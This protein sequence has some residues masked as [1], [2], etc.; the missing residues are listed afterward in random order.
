VSAPTPRQA[1]LFETG[2]VDWWREER[3]L[4]ARGIEWIAGLDEAGRGPLAGPVVAAAVVARHP[5]RIE[6]MNDS[7][8]LSPARRALLKRRIL[9][10]PGLIVGVGQ[11]S[12]EE[13]D[14]FNILNASLLAFFRAV[15]NLGTRPGYCLVDGNRECPRLEIPQKTLV[16]GDR[17]SFLVAAASVIAKETRD[18][19]MREYDRR[20]PQFGFSRHKGYATAF[21][22]KAIR[23]HGFCEIHRRSFD[24]VRSLIEKSRIPARPEAPAPLFPEPPGREVHSPLTG[25]R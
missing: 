5:V 6:G 16:G 18:A 17:L 22:K 4:F 19:L 23:E 7:K 11:A 14:R 24:P 25:R 15:S 12:V 21:H 9:D 20:Y 10:H 2:S 8:K 13:I 1:E 3:T